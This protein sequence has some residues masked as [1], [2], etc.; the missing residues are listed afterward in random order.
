MGLYEGL[1]LIIIAFWCTENF[2]LMVDFIKIVSGTDFTNFME[3]IVV[4]LNR[5][6][7]LRDAQAAK[8]TISVYK[9]HS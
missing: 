4:Y 9:M 1:L 5:N 3:E 2:L 8:V 6:I 7:F